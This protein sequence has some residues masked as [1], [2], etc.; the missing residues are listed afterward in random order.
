MASAECAGRVSVF[1]V[2]G[3]E[4]RVFARPEDQGA[5][6]VGDGRGLSARPAATIFSGKLKSAARKRSAESPLRIWVA[7]VAEEP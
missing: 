4:W 7:S 5:A 2:E 1:Y 6:G 3:L